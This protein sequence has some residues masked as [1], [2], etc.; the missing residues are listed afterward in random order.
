M[1]E[2]IRLIP[3]ASLRAEALKAEGSGQPSSTGPSTRSGRRSGRRSGGTSGHRLAVALLLVFMAFALVAL[4]ATGSASFV[5][6]RSVAPAQ[7][8]SPA[9]SQTRIT[10][11]R[12]GSLSVSWITDSPA[13]G[14]VSFGTTTALGSTA[15]DD[16]G[17]ATLDDTHHVTLSSLSPQTSY[18]FDVVSGSAVDDNGGT[19]YSVT[20]G[21]TLG[22]PVPDTIYGQVFLADGVTPAE[23]A[24]VYI[25]LMDGNGQGSSGWA[26]TMSALVDSNGWWTVN[27]GNSRSESLASYFSYS[28]DGDSVLIEAQGAAQGT[29]SETVDTGADMP[30][31]SITLVTTLP[32]YDFNNS[33]DVDIGDV[34]IIA[35]AWR[36]TD[37]ESLDRYNYNSN[38]FVD[39][40]DIMTVAKHLGEPCQ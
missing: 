26:V 4:R 17:I 32:C 22:L 10:N 24:I 9:I 16:R 23:G 39:I 37:A 20:T 14:H 19:H 5:G 36:A 31:A 1:R 18:Y 30:A 12:D 3:S 28:P 38:S 7:P 13:A 27:L 40:E 29:A 34:D 21:P 15:Y 2:T 8:A 25:T 6:Q 33:G 35:G 11:V